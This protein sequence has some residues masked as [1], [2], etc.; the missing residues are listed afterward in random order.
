MVKRILAVDYDV[1]SLFH[2][3]RVS[4][5]T[6]FIARVILSQIFIRSYCYT[7]WSVIGIILSSVCPSVCLSVRL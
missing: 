4:G 3:S 2:W 1:K 7:V 5:K 6:C